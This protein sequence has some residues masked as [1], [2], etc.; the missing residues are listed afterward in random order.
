MA[1]S[2]HL[3][4]L[5]KRPAAVIGLITAVYLG[6][7]YQVGLFMMVF[8]APGYAVL[9]TLPLIE[10]L[11][12]WRHGMRRAVW[13]EAK[14]QYYAYHDVRVHVLEDESHSR[15]VRAADIRQIFPALVPDCQL[16]TSYH[17]TSQYLGK[18]PALYVRD[19]TMTAHLRKV[20]EPLSLRLGT[21][22]GRSIW[23]PASKIRER[24]GIRLEEGVG[25]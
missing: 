21:W 23:F 7:G 11:R 1:A 8:T 9:V 5:L 19:D 2:V 22:I 6:I 14:G 4:A 13:Q 25:T 20:N 15:W 17:N 12:E 10:V 16:Q 18:K 3:K 24:Y